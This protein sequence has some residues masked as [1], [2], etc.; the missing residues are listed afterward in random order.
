MAR[1]DARMQS[2]RRSVLGCPEEKQNI[3]QNQIH[4]FAGFVAFQFAARNLETSK[5]RWSVARVALVENSFCCSC[6][7]GATFTKCANA[8]SEDRFLH[9]GLIEF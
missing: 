4:D 6:D 9:A 5:K 2:G 1:R 8:F 3:T 7:K